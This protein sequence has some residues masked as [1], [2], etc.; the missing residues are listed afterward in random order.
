MQASEF[1][2]SARDAMTVK[3][4]FGEPFE[5]DGVTIIPAAKIGGGAG[6]GSGD[7]EDGAGSGGGFGLSAKPAGAYVVRDGDVR[8]EPAI[9]VNRIVLG[10]QIVAVILALVIG[11]IVRS[12]AKAA[13][14]H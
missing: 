5:K 10:A 8:W 2:D 12:R 1:I 4:V 9:D 14:N 6:A 7:G 13:V 11:S 3:R